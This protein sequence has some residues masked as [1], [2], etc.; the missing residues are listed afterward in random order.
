MPEPPIADEQR[1]E[2]EGFEDGR[3]G[4]DQRGAF[5]D[6][7]RT[8]YERG[9]GR[10]QAELAARH[11]ALPAE[12][13]RRAEA[14]ARDRAQ[15]NQEA[16]RE[17]VAK[18]TARWP[19]VDPLNGLDADRSATRSSRDDG[20]GSLRMVSRRDSRFLAE[21]AQAQAPAGATGA[22]GRVRQAYTT[23]SSFSAS[24]HLAG[25]NRMRRWRAAVTG[26]SVSP[27]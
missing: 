19:R 22:T 5:P 3:T 14:E 17:R 10:A 7:L 13:Q 15:A 6:A 21:Q 9:L 20:R 12:Q 27:R 24:P 4:F 11:A 2:A 26:S 25:E 18:A 1:A 8:A 16:V 23:V